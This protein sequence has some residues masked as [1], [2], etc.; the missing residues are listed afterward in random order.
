MGGYGTVLDMLLTNLR[1]KARSKARYD[2]DTSNVVTTIKPYKRLYE[3]PFIVG[4][5]NLSAEKPDKAILA[6]ASRAVN[7]MTTIQ[8]EKFQN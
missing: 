4:K 7:K 2:M 1:S 3:G 5:R 6:V 8:R